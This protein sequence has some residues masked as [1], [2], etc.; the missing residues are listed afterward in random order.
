MKKPGTGPGR[1]MIMDYVV[2]MLVSLSAVVNVFTCWRLYQSDRRL[3][4]ATEKT[5]DIIRFYRKLS[6]G[7]ARQKLPPDMGRV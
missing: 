5:R 6:G 2:L 7:V 4:K 1:E 3:K